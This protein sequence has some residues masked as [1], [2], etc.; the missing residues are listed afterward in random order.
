MS[1]RFE[2]KNCC[3]NCRYAT[4]YTGYDDFV[5]GHCG[6]MLRAERFD[7]EYFKLDK[8]KGG[9]IMASRRDG[10][11]CS[12]YKN[13]RCLG[14]KEVEVCNCKG[15]TSVCDFYPQ[16]RNNKTAED[17][18]QNVDNISDTIKEISD[19]IVMEYCKDLDDL[20]SVIKEQLQNNGGITDTELEFLIMDLAN[21]L[22]FTGSAQE[23]LGIKED[24]CK[25]IRQEVYSK[26]R[27]QATGK[28]VADKTAQAELIAQTETMTL[29]IY[30]RA[31]KKV[32]LRMDAGYEMLNS[33]KKVMNKRI[34]EM[35][36]SN[37]RYINKS[38]VN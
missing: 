30:S 17:I 29:A 28:T 10:T 16:K 20:M 33:L 2:I 6:S 31:Y 22:Y 1:R 27:E 3:E 26:A 19:N 15:N 21:A 13:G 14:T 25:A 18:M 8:Y 12:C 11:V 24:T 32:K 23:D 34:A 7:C 4:N 9:I 35:E 5:C 37:S 38:E 36:L